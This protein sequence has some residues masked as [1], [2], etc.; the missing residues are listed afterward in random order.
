[1]RLA[2][3]AAL[4]FALTGCFGGGSEPLQR[5]ELAPRTSASAKVPE[6]VQ[7][8]RG[9]GAVLATSVSSTGTEPAD[10]PAAAPAEPTFEELA[11]AEIAL[12]V[13]AAAVEAFAAADAGRSRDV[14]AAT[15]NAEALANAAAL[16]DQRAGEVRAL[17]ASGGCG[18]SPSGTLDPAVQADVDAAVVFAAL[19][20]EAAAGIVDELNPAPQTVCEGGCHGGCTE[21]PGTVDDIA[22]NAAI[23]DAI[24]AGEGCAAAGDV[25]ADPAT[26]PL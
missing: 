7:L 14:A 6:R 15:A 3:V 21:V 22:L 26:A 20:A 25:L 1:M 23:D 12:T 5:A 11:V 4:P 24:R 18:S 8:G 2:L 16:V 9:L 13:D 17:S 19:A 10:E